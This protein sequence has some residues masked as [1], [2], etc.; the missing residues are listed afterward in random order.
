VRADLIQDPTLAQGVAHTPAAPLLA[1]V[2]SPPLAFEDAIGVDLILEGFLA[3][4]AHPREI[5]LTA[6]ADVVLAGDYCY[7]A[8]LVR[9][10]RANDLFVIDVLAQLVA[11]S[12]GVVARGHRAQLPTIWLGALAAITHHDRALA[13]DQFRD[14]VHHAVRF[15]DIAGFTALAI[16]L[17]DPPNLD[18]V[19]A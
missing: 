13:G 15:D 11:L 16:T 6:T 10:A 12:A 17:P 9:V 8:G 14:A 1:P 19:F 2:V 18:E 4:H 3:H 7:A 5:A